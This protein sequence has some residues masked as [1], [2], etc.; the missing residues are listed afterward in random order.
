MGRAIALKRFLDTSVL[1]ATVLMQ[2]PHHSRSLAV[3]SEC[4]KADGYCAAHSLAETYATLTRL[5]GNLRMSAE[6]ALLFI[7]DVRR[8]LT[9]VSLDE[10]EYFAVLLEAAAEDIGGGA[11]YDALIAHCAINSRADVL[12]TWDVTDFRRLGTNIARRVRTP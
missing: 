5:P 12:Y 3:Y 2:H 6:Q 4:R 11:I 8:R 1:V 10:S 9:I 7:E